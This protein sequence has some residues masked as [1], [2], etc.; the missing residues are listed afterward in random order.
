[1][2]LRECFGLVL[3]ISI[4]TISVLATT[5]FE[6]SQSRYY[7]LPVTERKHVAALI[8]T[9]VP[10]YSDKPEKIQIALCSISRLILDEI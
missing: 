7:G 5:S 10:S 1:M 3:R 6:F 2:Q 4:I 8:G 9:A